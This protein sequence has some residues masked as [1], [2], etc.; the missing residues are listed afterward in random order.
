MTS[1]ANPI[2]AKTVMT[3]HSNLKHGETTVREFGLDVKVSMEHGPLPLQW[4]QIALHLKEIQHF[5]E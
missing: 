4:Q 1:F 2:N 3:C 5:L